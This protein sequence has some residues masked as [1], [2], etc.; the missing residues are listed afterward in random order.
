[1]KRTNFY[2]PEALLERLKAAKEKTGVPVSEIIRRAVEA[3]LK[4]LGI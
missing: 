1:M 4:E 2:F 3:Y